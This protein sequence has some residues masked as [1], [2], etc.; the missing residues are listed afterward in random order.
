M[1]MWTGWK[2]VGRG[3]RSGPGGKEWD[4]GEGVGR[5]EKSRPG[6]KASAGGKGVGRGGG[7]ESAGADWVVVRYISQLP[8]FF[9]FDFLKRFQET[10]PFHFTEALQLFITQRHFCNSFPAIKVSN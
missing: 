7:K 4:G 1:K 6:G 9:L 2:G 10:E 5:G 8:R 3:E